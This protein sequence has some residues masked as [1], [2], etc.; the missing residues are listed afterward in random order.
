MRMSKPV[1]ERLALVGIGLI[2]SS[3]ARVVKREKLAGHVAITTRSIETLKRAE[4]LELGDSYHSDLAK[5]VRDAECVI[6]SVPVGSSGAI[7]QAMAPVL[8]QG[9]IVTDVGS[10]KASVIAQMQ[11]HIPEACISFQVIH[12][13]ETRNPAPMPALPTCSRTGG[14]YSRP[15]PE[16]IRPQ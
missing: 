7:A 10:T 3:L 2:G 8:R 11:P 1:F 14:A 5:C 6:V 13:P 12:S 4:Q 15:C 9:A 16:P